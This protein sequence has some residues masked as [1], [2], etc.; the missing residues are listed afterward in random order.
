LYSKRYGKICFINR[1]KQPNAKQREG[2]VLPG[3]STLRVNGGYRAAANWITT[4]GPKYLGFVWSTYTSRQA[5]TRES[6]SRV[7]AFFDQ[8]HGTGSD[9]K[10]TTSSPRDRARKTER[11]S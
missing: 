4:R 3:N 10:P 6:S 5:Q 9:G 1:T 11:G 8:I 7:R 2:A